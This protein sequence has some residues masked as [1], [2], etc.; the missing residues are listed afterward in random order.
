MIFFSALYQMWWDS[1][2]KTPRK[3][4]NSNKNDSP[5]VSPCHPNLHL[6]SK[7]NSLKLNIKSL[8]VHSSLWVYLL[9]F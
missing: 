9:L 3:Y 4:R 2:Q 1:W 7:N 6:A 5:R 8:N